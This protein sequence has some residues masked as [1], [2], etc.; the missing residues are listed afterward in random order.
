MTS[1]SDDF[2]RANGAVGANWVDPT[3]LWVVTSQQLGPGSAGG[4]IYLRAAT[5]MATNDHYAQITITATAAA[6]HG[7]WIR[8]N[9]TITQGYLVR[10]NGSSWDLFY[11]VGGSF[12]VIG[13]YAAAAAANDVVKLQAIG[14]AIKV[15]INETQRISVTDT[16]VPTGTNVGVRSDSTSAIRFDDFSAA[17]ISSGTTVALT[18]ASATET[19]QAL[20]GAKVLALAASTEADGAQ[21]LAGAKAGTLTLAAATESAQS[22]T[23]GKATTLSPAASIDAAQLV[24]GSKAASLGVA[25]ASDTAQPL[26]GT[27]TVTLGIATEVD[28]AQAVAGTKTALL[29]PAVEQSAAQAFNGVKAASLGIAG[30]V[31]AAEPITSTVPGTL[32]AAEAVEMALPLV[33][34]KTATLV[35]AVEVE[36]AHL[37]TVPSITEHSPEQTFRIPAGRRKLTVVAERRRFTVAAERRTSTVRR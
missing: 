27:K 3:G 35:P 23:G 11:V 5:A 25:A 20:T 1:F 34:A 19:A 37:I 12:T 4:T 10:N 16:V 30:S 26:V 18:L 8:G 36:A 7:I 22:L 15:Y 31:E 29:T 6:S 24:T 9:T 17:D 28:G 13:T 32:A 14:S 33:G 2:N 21:A